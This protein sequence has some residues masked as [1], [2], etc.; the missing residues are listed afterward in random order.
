M[1]LDK[2]LCWEVEGL[3]HP[4]ILQEM[5][6]QATHSGRREAEWMIC[7]GHQHG[8]PH[9]DPQ[10]DVSAVQSFGPQTSREEIWDLYYQVYKLTRLL[11]SPLCGPEWAGELLRDIVSS[12][13]NC[14]R[15][16]EDEQPGVAQAA[17]LMLSRTPWGERGGQNPACQS[18][19]SP[20]EGPG[21]HH[22]FGRKDRAAELVPY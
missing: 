9:L 7:W 22:H 11:R 14:L 10:A 8:L 1:V 12:L 6:L 16:R 2:H 5:F 13:K 21:N 15:L 17:H 4:L 18:E 20:L 3:H 19:R